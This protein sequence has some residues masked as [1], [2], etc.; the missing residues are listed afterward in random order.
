MTEEQQDWEPIVYSDQK[1]FLF[2]DCREAFLLCSDAVRIVCMNVARSCSCLF[3]SA[4]NMKMWF[5]LLDLAME[6][7]FWNAK[8]SGKWGAQGSEGRIDIKRQVAGKK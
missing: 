6:T 1:Q 5:G 7:S 3:S 2:A 8:Q 4:E